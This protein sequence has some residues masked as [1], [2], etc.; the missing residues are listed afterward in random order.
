[1]DNITHS[2]LGAALS[3]AG[4]NRVLAVCDSGEVSSRLAVAN[5]GPVKA[6][7]GDPCRRAITAIMILAANL[8]DLD[9]ATL[10]APLLYLEHHR[11]Y[12]HTY[13]GIAVLALLLPLPFLKWNHAI[14][15]NPAPVRNKYLYLAGISLLGTASHLFLDFTNS[16]GVRPLRPLSQRW[17]YGDFIP[18]IDPWIYL[19]L[20]SSLFLANQMARRR[21]TKVAQRLV[22]SSLFLL[23]GYYLLCWQAHRT[24]LNLLRSEIA[25]GQCRVADPVRVAAI[26]VAGAPFRWTFFIESVDQYYSGQLQLADGAVTGLHSVS[27]NLAGLSFRRAGE[28][29]AGKAILRFARFP[30][31]ELGERADGYVVNLRDLRFAPLPQRIGFASVSIYFDRQWRERPESEPLCPWSEAF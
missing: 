19:I 21:L 23:C 24:A 30:V 12:T 20:G 28:T 22:L 1:M 18:I 16:Y 14:R 11:G 15:S 5:L 27:K 8:P 4:L 25:A 31:L 7:V 13:W 6:A 3:H 29:C 10:R 26:P 2:L 17:V 9:V